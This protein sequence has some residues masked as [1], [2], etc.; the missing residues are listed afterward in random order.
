MKP[1]RRCADLQ[2]PLAE[3]LLECAA[4]LIAACMGALGEALSAAVAQDASGCG[5]LAAHEQVELSAAK[6][7]KH[8]TQALL[9]VVRKT[10]LTCARCW[11]G[12]PT[13]PAPQTPQPAETEAALPLLLK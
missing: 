2:Q 13:T 4:D 11:P 8:S 3:R 9:Q 5:N 10:G 7:L 6:L 12:P 1:G